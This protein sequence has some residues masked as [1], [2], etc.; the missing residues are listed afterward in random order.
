MKGLVLAGGLGT[1]LSPATRVV[2]K[3]LL[4]VYDKPMV[5]YSLSVLMLAGIREILVITTPRDASQFKDLLQDGAQWGL[6]IQYAVQAEP[7]GL[8][9]AFIVAR[10]FIGTDPCCLILGD[11][12]FYGQGLQARLVEASKLKEGALIFGYRVADPARYGVIEFAADGRPARI[13]EKPSHSRSSWAVTGLYFYDNS[14][15]EIAKD[16]RPSSRGQLEITDVNQRYLQAGKLAVQLLGR[17]YAWL[18]AGTHD[19]LLAAAQF[20]QAIEQRQGLKV[21]CL[22]EIAYRKGYITAA[23]LVLLARSFPNDD[24]ASY[25]LDIVEEKP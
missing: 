18:D 4:P 24:Y 22:E 17:G 16:V 13:E 19:S 1:R 10:H 12:I 23:Q 2:S 25:L 5:Y 3:Q 6:S 15:V 8:A 20:V 9:Q 21:A 11:N 7:A 14:V